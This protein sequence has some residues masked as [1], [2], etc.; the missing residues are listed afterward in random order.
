MRTGLIAAAA[1]LGVMA[2]LLYV[3]RHKTGTPAR[4]IAAAGI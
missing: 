3:W 2:L 1:L 4:G